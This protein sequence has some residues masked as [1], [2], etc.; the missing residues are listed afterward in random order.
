MNV[1]VIGA[2]GKTGK[3]VV[4]KALKAGHQVTAFVHHAEGY[5]PAS[6]EVRV[7]EGDAADHT[8]MDTAMVDQDAVIDTVAVKK[9]YK[10]DTIEESIAQVVLRAMKAHGVRRLAAVSALGVGSSAKQAPFIYEHLLVPTMLRGIIKGKARME[11]TI[12]NADVD[13]VIARPALLKDGEPTGV[14]VYIE[15]HKAHSITRA[16]VAHFLVESLQNDAYLGQSVT[17]ASN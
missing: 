17:I 16:D 9:P 5:E 10:E 8:I 14:T 4:E 12:A 15:G 3:L 1:L 11:S 2:A 13:Y 7:V 6:P